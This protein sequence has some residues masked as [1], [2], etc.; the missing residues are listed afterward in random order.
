[1]L[2]DRGRLKGDAARAA[3]DYAGPV[4]TI[5]PKMS[6]SSDLIVD[7]LFG[8]GLDR[9]LTGEAAQTVDALNASG[10]PVLAVDL[11]SGIDG[12]TGKIQGIA[13][14]A[15]RT[16][17]FFRLKPGHLLLPGRSHC[18]LTEVA[19]IGIPD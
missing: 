15:A 11:P 10:A 8:A 19:Q 6:L 5:G 3:G 4:E 18:G 2:G 17:T 1:M 7:A 12:R 16:V 13:V 9:P 14:Q